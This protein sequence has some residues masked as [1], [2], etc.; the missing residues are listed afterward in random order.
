MQGRISA[1]LPRLQPAQP[2]LGV[3][4]FRRLPVTEIV[5]DAALLAQPSGHE[6][7]GRILGGGET[8]V[9]IDPDVRITWR[10]EAGPGWQ[11]ITTGGVAHPKAVPTCFP[12]PV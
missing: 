8:I 7:D 6:R 9:D 2:R 1:A 4:G 12:H 10:L 5:S 3:R 11:T